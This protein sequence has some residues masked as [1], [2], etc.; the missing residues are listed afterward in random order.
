MTLQKLVCDLQAIAHDGRA[1]SEVVAADI[2]V[3]AH[4][5]RNH[6]RISGAFVDGR[7]VVVACEPW[8]RCG[9]NDELR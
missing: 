9:A 8:A 2:G 5:F 7:D 6:R 3:R 4:G 1:Q